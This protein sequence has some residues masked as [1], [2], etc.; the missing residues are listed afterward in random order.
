MATASAII[1]D[2]AEES[3]I[4][5]ASINLG[6]TALLVITCLLILKPFI[7]LLAWGTIIAIASLPRFEKLKKSLS[8]RGGWAAVIGTFAL[9][10]IPSF[11][12]FLVARGVV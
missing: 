11:P 9:L 6:L 2:K 3:R 10:P 12:T 1:H 4:L 5:D 7:P 8:G